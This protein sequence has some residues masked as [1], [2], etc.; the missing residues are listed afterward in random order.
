M[1]DKVSHVPQPEQ[2][3]VR[4]TLP[5]GIDPA[6]IGVE[7]DSSTSEPVTADEIREYAASLGDTHAAYDGP[8]PTAP[9]TFCVRFRGNRF[10]H[11]AIP[12]KVFLR[13]FDAGKDIEFG[14]PIRVGDVVHTSNLLHEIY[15]K[16]G[17][18]GSMIFIVTRQT[19]T[20]Q[21]GEKLA[22]IDS[23]FVLRPKK[24]DV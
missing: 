21:R 17:R 3:S 6:L 1:T 11:P 9:P 23:R 14:V 7:F 13:G 22:V 15:E 2:A 16:T 19:M 8:N 10:F 12:T 20:N 4:E 5:L 18:S 24:E